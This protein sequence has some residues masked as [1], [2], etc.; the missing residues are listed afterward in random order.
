M[1]PLRTF[2]FKL[3][4][5]FAAALL[6]AGCGLVTGPSDA[7][8]LEAARAKW[9]SQSLR[10]SYSFDISRSCYCG[11]PGALPL[12]RVWVFDG[13]I[14]L[15]HH[16]HID[17]PIT[18]EVVA[19]I[20][21]VDGLFDLIAEAI[22]NAAHEVRVRYEPDT[23]A[24]LEIRIDRIRQAIDDELFIETSNFGV[25]LINVPTSHVP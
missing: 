16:P 21:T 8:L 1:A 17:D 2:P 13:R 4:A 10:Q 20:P 6:A 12:T 15:A 5:T 18:A 22:A 9:N 11:Y 7:D 3:G 19:T 14:T 25:V 24:P 23:G